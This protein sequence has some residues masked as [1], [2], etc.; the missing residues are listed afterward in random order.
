MNAIHEKDHLRSGISEAVHL[1]SP[2]LVP[3]YLLDYC[4]S[5]CI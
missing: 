3:S 5:L 1:M 2:F 4:L